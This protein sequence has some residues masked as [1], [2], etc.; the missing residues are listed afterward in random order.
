MLQFTVPQFIDVEDKIFG[1]ITVR[2]FVIMLIGFALIGISYKIFDF[3]AF[4]AVGLLIF[5]VFGS[6]AFLKINGRPFHFF[7]LNII[8]TL[9]KPGLRVWNHTIGRIDIEQK[10]QE[11]VTETGPPLSKRFTTS[12]LAELALI[13]DTSGAYQGEEKSIEID[14]D[15]IE[16]NNN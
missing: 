9:K 5:A 4:I 1:P 13:V 10:I 12:R 6:I 7:V 8:Q 16:N 14:V 11:K 2:Q 3:S 15:T